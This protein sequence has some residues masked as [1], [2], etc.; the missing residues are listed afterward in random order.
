[1]FKKLMSLLLSILM[2]LSVFGASTVLAEDNETEILGPGTNIETLPEIAEG[3]NRYFFYMPK[4]WENEYSDTAG[5]YWWEGT[6][7]QSSWPG[8]EAYKADAEGLY[9]YDVPK[10]VSSVMWNNYIDSGNDYE[11]PEYK[12]SKTSGN[13]CT[14]YYE[15]GESNLYPDGLESF[16]NMVWVADFS[17]CYCMEFDVRGVCGDWYYYYG[18]GEYGTTSEKGDVVYTERSMNGE[19]CRHKRPTYSDTLPELSANS[20]RYFFYVPDSWQFESRFDFEVIFDE[21]GIAYL[22]YADEENIFFCDLPKNTK[23]FYIVNKDK[24]V[25][26]T[27]PAPVVPDFKLQ[28]CDGKILVIDPSWT[29][30]SIVDGKDINYGFWHYYY[31]NGEYGETPK[32][33]EF[34]YPPVAEGCNRYFFYMPEFWCNDYTD[35]AGIYWW[36]GTGAQSSYP[37]LKANKADAEGVYYYDVPKDVESIIWNNYMD[38]LMEQMESLKY[39]DLSTEIIYADSYDPDDTVTYPDGLESFNGM[40]YVV[41]GVKIDREYVSLNVYSGEWY[42]YYG[43][44]EY[45]ITPNRGDGEIYSDA[46]IKK[47]DY[48]LPPYLGDAD[49][50][51]VVNIKDATHIQKFVAGMDVPEIFKPI[52]D[53]D[54]SG[55]ITVKDATAIQKYLAG[56]DT[57]Y[58]IGTYVLD[59]YKNTQ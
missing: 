47:E 32:E 29:I 35:T 43:N 34:E 9:Y 13:I 57:G 59:Y 49:E 40:I 33:E 30:T 5:I 7:A 10:D 8:V 39:L 18:N 6:G 3:C 16:N 12:A 38:L 54:G 56:M 36:E 24:K 45:G 48:L 31:G 21:V 46:I 28:D 1:M 51:E 52:G 19:Y 27:S 44:G 14:E 22:E 26:S 2:I 50:N 58:K 37:G 25:C 4:S 15:A 42:Y 53:V 23:E 17:E 41:S 20:N 11:S 55:D